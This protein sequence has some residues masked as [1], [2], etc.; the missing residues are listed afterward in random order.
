MASTADMVPPA[1]EVLNTRMMNL[2]QRIAGGIRLVVSALDQDDRHTLREAA[3]N[4]ESAGD[5][6]LE[7]C[8]SVTGDSIYNE[9]P[10]TSKAKLL[11]DSVSQLTVVVQ[12]LFDNKSDERLRGALDNNKKNVVTNI[13]TLVQAVNEFVSRAAPPVPA[14]TTPDVPPPVSIPP[15][16]VPPPTDPEPQRQPESPIGP[17]PPQS[18]KTAEPPAPEPPAPESAELKALKHKFAENVFALFRAVVDRKGDENVRKCVQN[19]ISTIHELF[20]CLT[21]GKDELKDK[22]NTFGSLIKIVNKNPEANDVKK[23]ME[24]EV[25]LILSF[26]GEPFPENV[27][28]DVPPPPLPPPPALP[29][30]PLS[31]DKQAPQ[32][33]SPPASPTKPMTKLMTTQPP[34]PP[35]VLGKGASQ[36]NKSSRKDKSRKSKRA[37]K[38]SNQ[39]EG[40]EEAEVAQNPGADEQ[41]PAAVVE[42]IGR[43]LPEFQAIW[44]HC[45]PEQQEKILAEM[46]GLASGSAAAGTP[47]AVFARKGE[48][49]DS[50]NDEKCPEEDEGEEEEDDVPRGAFL[51]KKTALDDAPGKSF[52]SVNSRVRRKAKDLISD[53]KLDW[54]RWQEMTTRLKL[55]KRNVDQEAVVE[56]R[57]EEE[58][59]QYELREEALENLVESATSFSTQVVELVVTASRSLAK[60]DDHRLAGSAKKMAVQSRDKLVALMGDV[61]K[62][63]DAQI[64]AP[65]APESGAA[66]AAGRPSSKGLISF[67]KP[68][69]TKL[70]EETA[71][72]IREKEVRG[73]LDNA[74]IAAAV[75]AGFAKQIIISDMERTFFANCESLRLIVEQL[76]TICASMTENQDAKIEMFEVALT[77]N[78]FMK[79]LGEL[80]NRFETTRTL[81]LSSSGEGDDL[82]LTDQKKS[83]DRPLWSE[84]LDKSAPLV[85]YTDDGSDKIPDKVSLNRLIEYLTSP[86]AKPKHREMFVMSASTFTTPSV[87][88]DKLIE[89]YN[90][91][92]EFGKEPSATKAEAVNGKDQSAS[93]AE[94][95]KRIRLLVI[96]FMG[97]WVKGQFD[98]FDDNVIH[99]LKA[100]L[101]SPAVEDMKVAAQRLSTD[102][103]QAQ[104]KRKKRTQFFAVPPT[105]LMIPDEKK[106]PHRLLMEWDDDEIARQ[107]TLIDYR[108]FSAIR[109]REMMNQAWLKSKLMHRAPN[110]IRMTRRAPRISMW[111][112]HSV[113]SEE[114]PEKRAQ[115]CEKFVRIAVKLKEFHNYNSLAGVVAG[116]VASYVSRLSKT[117]AC[118]SSGAR[119][120]LKELETFVDPSGSFQ[121][122]RKALNHSQNKAIPMMCTIEKDLIFADE[123][124]DTLAVDGRIN[125]SKCAIVCQTINQIGLF[126]N[127]KCPFCVVEPLYSF[128]SE[129]PE[130]TET[131]FYNIS[132]EREPRLRTSSTTRPKKDDGAKPKRFLTLRG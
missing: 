4:L 37:G 127:T 61:K 14:N 102:I 62:V 107:L 52:V 92:E 7:L 118:M 44:E 11:R 103:T 68:T 34:P 109:P 101:D 124:N 55:T 1:P 70:L 16:P 42:L 15:P 35:V 98:E 10:L 60:P 91:P 95:V 84:L 108:L 123:G 73:V 12:T 25:R 56:S 116:L 66:A 72:N 77:S 115:I 24:Q 32:V 43:E 111:V 39:N 2:V 132:L 120:K 83:G 19:Y 59:K 129:L 38:T 88:L 21:K 50:E 81:K 71:K 6:V 125:F 130:Y 89:R 40:E 80:L 85:D 97:Y 119:D 79:A 45:P 18:P 90:V 57:T 17:T 20:P 78:T 53:P 31:L 41:T 105:E 75:S 3:K 76:L 74:T 126:Q 117:F 122:Y 131:D 63:M 8:A 69:E 22:V 9:H 48:T 54:L 94:A 96:I 112:G 114:T 64:R 49:T 113:L 29:P 104:A 27:E 47:P 23:Q 33:E 36:K 13:R 93:R 128:L 26:L 82:M 67:T 28:P 5:E 100:F 121:R 46:R 86:G 87:I 110:M 106:S 65:K 58:R 99:R 30:S 51:G